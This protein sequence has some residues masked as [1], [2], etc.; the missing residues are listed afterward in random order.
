MV[1]NSIV[2]GKKIIKI[3]VAKFD[4]FNKED[5]RNEIN[6]MLQSSDKDVAIDLSDVQ[7]I[8]SSGLSVLISVLKELRK[9]DSALTLC[10]LQEQPT[11]L[12]EITQLGLV[13][14]IE[15]ECPS[16]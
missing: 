6:E 8:D 2:N 7:F 15:K 12:M 10:G 1:T 16:L 3:S 14:K 13:F 4:V 5:V 9:A 11:E